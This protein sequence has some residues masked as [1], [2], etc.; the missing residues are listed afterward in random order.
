MVHSRNSETTSANNTLNSTGQ[1]KILIDK[2]NSGQ[3]MGEDV[4]KELQSQR[5]MIARMEEKL[6]KILQFQDG[7]LSEI[8]R[9]GKFI[10]V[11]S[12]WFS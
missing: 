1:G 9:R 12:R 10:L 6:D 4:F 3:S 11:Y 8:F 2:A 7:F 5:E